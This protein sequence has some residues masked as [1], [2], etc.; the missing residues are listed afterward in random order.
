MIA[1]MAGLPLLRPGWVTLTLPPLAAALL[2]AHHPQPELLFQYGLPLVVP[3]L[4]AGGL[5]AAWL[6]D[7]TQ[8]RPPYWVV[9]VAAGPALLIGLLFCPLSRGPQASPPALQP[10]QHG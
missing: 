2:S 7:R 6:M 9:A 1:G 4:V 5:G 10:P 8:A 3:V